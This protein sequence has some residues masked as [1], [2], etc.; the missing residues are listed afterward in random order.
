MAEKRE[1][2]KD[3]PKYIF[4]KIMKRSYG[5]TLLELLISAAIFVV[6]MVSIYSAFGAGMFG[7]KDIE[8]NI[9][10]S[11]AARQILE[12]MNLDLRNSFAYSD[13][14]AKFKGERLDISFL[15][16][17]DSFSKD[18]ITQ[19]YAFISYKLEGDKLMRL[20]MKNQEALKET[21]EIG[22]EEIA[23]AI[24]ELFFSYAEIV[25]LGDTLEWKDSFGEAQKT[26]PAAV[27]VKLTLKSKVKEEFERTIYIPL[28]LYK[29]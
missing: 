20:C 28:A 19:D 23:A 12:R 27:K 24:E 25:A 15:S 16:V 21:S 2:R 9:R 11:Q 6:A 3:K 29:K 14:D 5:F 18:E 26:L 17:L 22:A 4:I 8:E 1:R 10:I 13:S 7:Y